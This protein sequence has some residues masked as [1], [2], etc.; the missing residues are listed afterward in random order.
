M[1]TTPNR[2][3]NRTLLKK[4]GLKWA[5]ASALSAMLLSST[6]LPVLADAAVAD[7]VEQVSP[8]VVTILVEQDGRMA[9]AGGNKSPAPGTP[10]DD[11]FRRFGA[12]NGSPGDHAERGPS[13]A[14]G[15]GFIVDAEG[16]IVTNN[17]V[18]KGGDRIK[19]RLSDGREFNAE[20]MGA[21]EQTDLALLRIQVDEALPYVTL[22]NS[23][24]IRVGEDVVAV[25]NPFG[26]GG[27]VTTGIVSAKGRNIGG[28][29]Y[30]E[31]LQTD[32]SINKGNSGGPLFDMDGN[33]IGVNS[34]IFSP[35][36]GSVGI[37]FAVTS[38]I[39]SMIVDD[40]R[41]DGKVDRGWLGV[42]IQDLSPDI[43]AAMGL[44]N[45]DG[46]LVS[47]VLP[48]SPSQ[49][50]L[51]PGDVIT[52]FG[53]K[54]VG[55]S[56]DLPKLVAAAKSGQDASIE[57]IRNGRVETLTVQVGAYDEAHGEADS[58]NL[59]PASAKALGV[60]VAPL[61]ETA[62]AEIGVDENTTGVVVTSLASN[63]AAARAGLRVGDV[64]VRLGDAPVTTPQSLKSALNKEESSA[65]LLLIN[66]A[67]RQIFVAVPF[68]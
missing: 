16:W 65:A 40:L 41:D 44:D 3:P 9:K 18:I 43:A 61:T 57:V 34:A 33:V 5:G 13:S 46:A 28:G 37:G 8:S 39:V 7:L 54:P 27:T 52:A 1:T 23:D 60:T 50:V 45:R 35:S 66:R 51:Q 64:I 12:P 20:V 48:D 30:A 36:G 29:A 22:G 6:A 38:N 25:G 53:G 56:S 47:E 26:L 58:Q 67:G 32:A 55:S 49:G 24:E 17:H 14:L 59:E 42:S 10:F 31:F 63:G 15:S 21:D 11:F 68:A 2:T 4:A 19:V 62:R